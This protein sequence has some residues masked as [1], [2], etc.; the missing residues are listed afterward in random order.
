MGA[1]TLMGIDSLSSEHSHAN[2]SRVS[3]CKKKAP[4]IVLSRAPTSNRWEGKLVVVGS[5]AAG[6]DLT[7]LAPLPWRKE[8]FKSRPAAYL[9][10]ANSVMPRSIYPTFAARRITDPGRSSFPLLLAG[11]TWRLRPSYAAPATFS[12][13]APFYIVH[14]ACSCICNIGLWVPNL[15]FLCAGL[16]L[17]HFSL[18]GSASFWPNT[19]NNRAGSAFRGVPIS[20]NRFS[21]NVS[22]RIC[23]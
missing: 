18:L 21:T 6:N 7:D 17:S 9:N 2:R 23:S 22:N 3:S 5:V 19:K 8:S 14:G 12:V 1:S 4:S 15:R 20:E 10:V 16:V 11:F 13:R